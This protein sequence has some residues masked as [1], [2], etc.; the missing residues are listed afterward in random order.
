MLAFELHPLLVEQFQF[1]SLVL[2]HDVQS[3]GDLAVLLVN[4]VLLDE[5]LT[6]NLLHLSVRFLRLLL[7][8]FE[9]LELVVLVLGHVLR[10][11]GLLALGD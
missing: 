11:L 6:L 8:G 4:A 1:A 9:L 10:V 5:F 7:E 3:L 2:L